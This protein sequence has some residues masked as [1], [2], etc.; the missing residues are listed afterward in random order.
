MEKC[1]LEDV[2]PA[3]ETAARIVK[4]M[5]RMHDR[6]YRPGVAGT[7]EA[8]NVG[9]PGDWEGRA[10][11]A[12]SLE[13]RALNMEPAYLDKLVDWIFH[14]CNEEGYRGDII[15]FSSINEQSLAGHSWLLRG[16][17]EYY[18]WKKDSRVLEKIKQIVQKLYLPTKGK[19]IYYPK[20]P[21]E[22]V[23]DG[24]AA[25]ELTGLE[26]SG[27]KVSSDTGCAFISLDGLSHVYELIGDPELLE[28]L[29]EMI[30]VFMTID[31]VGIS[32]QTH[33]TLTACRGIMR[34]YSIHGNPEYLSFCQKM[35][36]VYKQEGMTENY[37]NYNLFSRPSW[38][39]PCGVIDSFMLAVFLWEASGNSSYIKDAH[40]IWYNGVCRG[41]RPNGGFGCDHC[42]E[43]GRV[44]THENFYEAYWCCSMR[45]GEGTTFASTCS[46]RGEKER[47]QFLFYFD[48]KYQ[49]PWIPGLVLSMESS[50]P[51]TGEI[52]IRIEQIPETQNQVEFDFY[53]PK[54]AQ[55]VR[56]IVGGTQVES[57]LEDS[58]LKTVI[59]PERGTEICLQFEIPLFTMPVVGNQH[60][61]SGLVTLRHGSL[62][63]GTESQEKE[64]DVAQLKYK[65]NGV[66]SGGGRIFK[67]LDDAYMM[68]TE[69]LKEVSYRILFQN[70]E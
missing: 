34:L 58:F 42:V 49:I 3:G 51:R 12:L 36:E 62:I 45:G 20:K 24:K 1:K 7:S 63:L 48:G 37:A 2:I 68:E 61:G 5:G 35:F 66:Y 46:L 8:E 47:L 33:A 11:L 43:D 67:P 17:I 30:S 50:Y 56:C 57:R 53:I 64:V 25:G 21:D 69:Q 59:M 14:N 38:T 40:E 65:G 6:I 32:M 31:F 52:F 23:Y 27:W 19:Y 28:L 44:R 9:W 70:A 39:E 18:N 55:N 10:V 22:R 54:W 4:N 15:D 41:Q 29:E 60:K 26:F 16:L 13:A